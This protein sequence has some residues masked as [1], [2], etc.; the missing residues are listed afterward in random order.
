MNENVT[1]STSIRLPGDLHDRLRRQSTRQDR[2]VH[3]LMLRYI[4]LGL[5]EDERRAA[6]GEEQ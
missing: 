6:E 1:I 5:T 3:Y 2:S 4:R